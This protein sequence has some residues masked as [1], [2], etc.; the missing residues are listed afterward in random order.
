MGTVGA[1][2]NDGAVPEKTSSLPQSPQYLRRFLADNRS[3]DR[4]LKS[5]V[6]NAQNAQI[7]TNRAREQASS[8]VDALFQQIVQEQQ[9]LESTPGHAPGKTNASLVKAIGVLQEMMRGST[10]V[11]EAYS[12]FQTEIHPISQTP[13]THVPQAY[14]KV[15]FELLEKLVEAKQAD[16]FNETLPNVSHIFRLFAE[17]GELKP[18]QWAALVGELVRSIINTDPSAE[19][20]SIAKYEG[21]LATRRAMLADLVESWKVLSLPRLTVLQTGEDELTDGYWFPR[22][23]RF[24]LR[25]YAQKRDFNAAFCTLFPQYPSNQLTPRIVVLAIITYALMYDS[26][27]CPI[28][29]RRDATPFTTKVADLV[30]F[31]NYQDDTF[32]KDLAATFPDLEEFVMGI[33]PGLRADLGKNRPRNARESI[34]TRKI[35]L[36]DN[37]DRATRVFDA[38]LI[39]N[40]LNQLQGHGNLRELDRLWG[41]FVGPEETI[42]EERAAQIRENPN[43][44]DSFIKTRMS[45]NQPEKAIAAWNVMGQVGLKPSLRTWNLMLDGLRRAGNL[46]GIKNIWAKM[47]K[48]GVTLDTGVWTTRIAGL[49]DCGDIEGGLQAL[50]EM[51]RLWEKVPRGDAVQPTI[52]PVNAAL[53]GLI[54]RKYHDAADRL[55]EWAGRKGIQPDVVTYNTML[56]PLVREKGRSKDVERLFATMQAQG[57]RADEG[58]FVIVLDSSFLEN[59]IRDPEDQTRIVDEVAAAMT[60][61]GLEL[62]M[63]TYGKM[64]YLLLRSNARTP[65][66]AVV[67]HLYNRNLELSPHIYTMLVENCFAQSPPD[68]NSVHLFVQRRRRLDFDDLDRVFYDRVVRGYALA[69]ETQAALDVY[70]H[71]AK[72]GSTVALGVLE[73][74]LRALTRVD[75]FEDAR[76]IVNYEKNRFES[77]NTDPAEHAGYWGHQ[78]WGLADSYGLL[79]TPLP[80]SQAS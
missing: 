34:R 59:D 28:N 37:G 71:V 27:R 56:R 1:V 2:P 11:V 62:N 30:T 60:A 79:D 63:K 67:N 14:R 33:W 6:Q 74:L 10:P 76:Y 29:I 9:S 75:R 45:L 49:V 55:L 57:V 64:I 52:E 35:S 3:R 39:R 24:S 15:K 16:M 8:R 41:Q 21:Q 36:P 43:L 22:L 25:K 65:A 7:T 20:D 17:A 77:H 73:D 53:A 44:I 42:S 38:V 12:Y 13:G 72:G 58:T 80:S 4:G 69:G 68:L 31:I 78:F 46:N 47:T 66:M 48:S 19:T 54:R 23:D 50:D 5:N 61:A 18:K 70:K 40:R 26:T 32:R 51:A